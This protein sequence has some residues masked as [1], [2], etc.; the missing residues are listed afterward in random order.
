MQIEILWFD[1][2]PNHER[3]LALLEDVLRERGIRE[4]VISVRVVD[5]AFAESVRFPGSPTIRIDGNDIEPGFEDPGEYALRCRVYRTS[6][7]LRGVPE[8][9]WIESVLDR[10]GRR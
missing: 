7:G 2:C 6:E 10:S 5:A 3:A 4:S 9:A 1:D 8:R